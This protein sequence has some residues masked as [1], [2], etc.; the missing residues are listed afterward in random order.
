[1]RLYAEKSLRKKAY[2]KQGAKTF[3]KAT[4]VKAEWPLKFEKPSILVKQK[5][6]LCA[7]QK[8]SPKSKQ[9]IKGIDSSNEELKD[10]ISIIP[11]QPDDFYDPFSDIRDVFH[12]SE[13]DSVYD[14]GAIQMYDDDMNSEPF[15]DGFE[16]GEYLW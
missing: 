16:F 1:V 10:V 2:G 5:K 15:L 7:I 13:F 14:I 3:K 12:Q 9:A 11:P 6:E 4:F 8:S